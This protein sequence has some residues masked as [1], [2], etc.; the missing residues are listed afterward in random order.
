MKDIIKIIAFGIGITGVSLL[1]VR[2]C[3]MA[4]NDRVI[5]TPSYHIISY[6]TGLN[7]HIEYTKYSDGSRDI[8][9]YPG[10]G[11]RLFDSQLF[12]DLDGDKKID[13]IRQNGS[14]WKMNSLSELLVRKHD[15]ETNKE[16]FDK[17]D[18]LLNELIN[19]YD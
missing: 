16:R 5:D 10:L 18:N 7:G 9:E 11:H 12:Q 1:G 2:G 13:R 17:A 15:Y 3:N 19:K 14:E 6:A 4:F 8:K